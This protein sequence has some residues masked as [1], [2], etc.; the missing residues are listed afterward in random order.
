MDLRVDIPVKVT[1]DLSAQTKQM[2]AYAAALREV[3]GASGSVN[4]SVAQHAVAPSRFPNGSMASGNAASAGVVPVTA[5]Q[6]MADMH[7]LSNAASS[8]ARSQNTAFDGLNAKLGEAQRKAAAL[9][10]ELEALTRIRNAPNVD[11]GMGIA[12][13]IAGSKMGGLHLLSRANDDTAYKKVAASVSNAED[14]V[15]AHQKRIAEKQNSID[16]S[17]RLDDYKNMTLNNQL[18]MSRTRTQEEVFQQAQIRA[19]HTVHDKYR[20]GSP[21]DVQMSQANAMNDRVNQQRA[22]QAQSAQSSAM[23]QQR[24]DTM[25]SLWGGMI[26]SSTGAAALQVPKFG[27]DQY[28]QYKRTEIGVNASQGAEGPAYIERAR[29]DALDMSGASYRDVINSQLQLQQAGDS[30]S[31]ARDTVLAFN[32]INAGTPGGSPDRLQR[33]LYNMSQVVNQGK[34]T[35]VDVRQF[36]QNLVPIDKAL[37]AYLNKSA[38]E[39]A[40][41]IPKG[42]ISSDDVRNALIQISKTDVY[43]GRGKAIS[44]GTPSGQWEKTRE[45]MERTG[46]IAG[47]SLAPAFASLNKGLRGTLEF[48]QAHPNLTKGLAWGA[49]GVGVAGTVGGGLMLGRS[50]T[51]Q[52]GNAIPALRNIPGVGGLFG[53]GSMAANTSATGANTLALEANTIAQGRAAVGGLVGGGSGAVGAGATGAVATGGAEAAAGAAGILASPIILGAA[54]TLA[55]GV[56]TALYLNWRSD[57]K[58]KKP[59]NNPDEKTER[60]GDTKRVD[61][62]TPEEKAS[63][64]LWVADDSKKSMTDRFNTLHHPEKADEIDPNDPESWRKAIDYSGGHDADVLREAQGDWSRSRS[65]TSQAVKARRGEQVPMRSSEEEL[66][67]WSEANGSSYIPVRNWA[68]PNSAGTHGGVRGAD[69]AKVKSVRE[70]SD[71]SRLVTL[72]MPPDP[73]TRDLQQ[74]TMRG[75]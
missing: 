72:L 52:L 3:A 32:D 65:A 51:G 64:Y 7:A 49:T 74:A 71:G 33:N 36:R 6:Q 44:E 54:A 21:L 22:R 47:E 4:G 63:Y 39:I 28:D 69:H 55:V 40:E 42:E 23:Y 58:D 12:S 53:E 34:L 41:M 75:R 45:E 37:S 29:K 56:G 2:L 24:R 61:E 43:R 38:K 15:A 59:V 19:N 9:R 35:G 13:N 67:A 30:T 5:S 70:N 10:Q 14:D 31:N 17:R 20:G 60:P 48:L 27:L 18:S 62:M 46:E 1:G 68:D 25:D 8:A 50:A 57:Q 66:R 26:L 73:T 16:A 11:V